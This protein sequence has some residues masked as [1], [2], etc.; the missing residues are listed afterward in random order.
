MMIEEKIA[1]SILH[2]QKDVIAKHLEHLQEAMCQNHAREDV[3]I[4]NGYSCH[5]GE[6]G[7][8]VRLE[9]S[10]K[11]R[12]WSLQHGEALDDMSRYW[13]SEGFLHYDDSDES[14][15]IWLAEQLIEG[16]VQNALE[17]AY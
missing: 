10:K 2:Q 17:E 13:A 12:S 15:W 6:P 11:S 4:N 7:M 1:K 9:Y 3:V 5:H 8:Y 14:N 16:V